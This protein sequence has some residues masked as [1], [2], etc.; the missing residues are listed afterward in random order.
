MLAPGVVAS[1]IAPEELRAASFIVTLY[2][3]VVEP[4][5]GLLWMGALVEVC[6]LVGVSETRA[7]T[8]VSRLVAAGRLE[9]TRVGRRSY[10]RLTPEARTEFAAAATLIYAPPPP[11]GWAFVIDPS[12]ADEA[13]LLAAGFAA[14]APGVLLGQD[15]GAPASGVRFRA[16][17]DGEAAGLQALAAARWDLAAPAAAYAAFRDRFGALAGA[18]DPPPGDEACFVARTLLVHAFRA[19]VLRDPRLP[20]EALPRDWPE[21]AARALFADLY[22]RLSPAADSFV[23][24]TFANLDGPLPVET[25][26]TR[27]RLD[28]LAAAAAP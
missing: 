15:A 10:Y 22:A 24:R 20:A 21:P 14:I 23:S 8:A 2:G 12:P 25:G 17:P 4:R 5:G 27:R 18:L 28:A 13:R 11:A 3:D 6:G 19:A 26:A 9:G 7:R 1:L 16:A